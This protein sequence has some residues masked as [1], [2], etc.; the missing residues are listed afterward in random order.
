MCENNTWAPRKN[1]GEGRKIYREKELRWA[2]S[3]KKSRRRRPRGVKG[4]RGGTAHGVG[5]SR[6][7]GTLRVGGPLKGKRGGVAFIRGK[8]RKT[9]VIQ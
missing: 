2:R 6:S 4:V 9:A 8:L 7:E 3:K 1:A 5:K